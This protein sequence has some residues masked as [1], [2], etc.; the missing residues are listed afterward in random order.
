MKTDTVLPDISE[1][2]HN[3][4]KHRQMQCSQTDLRQHTMNT[5]NT[6]IYNAARPDNTQ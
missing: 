2:T 1:T 4:H 3:E 6:D 5:D